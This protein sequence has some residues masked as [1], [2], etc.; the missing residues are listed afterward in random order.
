MSWIPFIYV[1]LLLSIACG[2]GYLYA[3]HALGRKPVFSGLI[4]ASIFIGA[5]CLIIFFICIVIP[6]FWEGRSILV[7]F[8]HYFIFLGFVYIFR[9]F[10]LRK[11]AGKMLLNLGRLKHDN[12]NLGFG[13]VFIVLSSLFLPILLSNLGSSVD[14][15]E[16]FEYIFF[17]PIGI[18]MLISGLKGTRILEKGITNSERFIV[19]DKIKSYEWGEGWSSNNLTIKM[20]NRFPWFRKLSLIIPK[21]NKEEVDILLKENVSGMG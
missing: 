4:Y 21:G 17:L 16:G 15:L 2:G 19:W 9:C 6:E 5:G 18:S 3:R 13:I 14:P 20:R 8:F 11:R 1:L 12:F 10:W 7:E